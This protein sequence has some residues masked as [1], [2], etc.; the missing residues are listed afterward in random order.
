VRID[1]MTFLHF[2]DGKIVEGKTLQDAMSLMRTLG[3]SPAAMHA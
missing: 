2:E 3:A 1:G